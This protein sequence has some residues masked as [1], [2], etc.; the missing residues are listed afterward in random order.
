MQKEIFEKSQFDELVVRRALYWLSAH[1]EW[2]LDEDERSWIVHYEDGL[3][4]RPILH[5]LVNDQILRQKLDNATQNL[6]ERL[7]SK[8]FAELSDG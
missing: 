4:L 6:R 8:V 3:E 5:R 7:I 2:T 1:C